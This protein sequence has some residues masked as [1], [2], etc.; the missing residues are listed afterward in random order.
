MKFQ[1]PGDGQEAIE[2]AY[3]ELREELEEGFRRLEEGRM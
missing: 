2:A 3:D 1:L